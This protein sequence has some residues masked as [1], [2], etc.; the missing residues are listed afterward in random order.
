VYS[1]S[2]TRDGAVKIANITPLSAIL[3]ALLLY[4]C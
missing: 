3:L 4:L 2:L 1:N